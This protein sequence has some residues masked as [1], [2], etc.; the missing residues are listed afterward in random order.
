MSGRR[1]VAIG[2]GGA[3]VLLAALDAY[4]VTTILV[5]VVKDL[6][7]PVNRLERVTPVLTGFLLGYVAAM[8]LLGQLSDRFGRR[9]VLQAC[10]VFFAAGSV[11]TALAHDVPVLTGGRVVQGVAGGALLPVTM[12]LAGDL[13][14]ERQRPVVLGAVGAAQELGSVLGPLY[15]A[16]IAAALDWRAIFWI[17]LPLVAVAMA[18]VQ[19]AVPGGRPSGPRP[20]VDVVGG[21]LLA[22]GLGLLVAAVYNPE[23]QEAALPPWGLPALGAGAAVLAVFVLWEIRSRKRLLDLS[24]VRRGPLLATLG[25]SLLSGA[26]LMVT[27]VDVVLV[28][29]TVLHKDVTDGAL[30]LTRFLVALPVAAVA[31]GLVARRVGERW[32]MAVGMAVSAGGYL[33]IA[34]WPADLAGASYGPLPRMDVD[35]VVTG[36]GLGLV[37]APVSSAVL[38]FVPAARHGVA[39]AAVVVARMMGMLL[40]ISALTAWG[41]H[42]FHAL[43]AD[44]KPPLPFLMSKQEFAAQ[45]KIY[46][47]ALQ[48]ALRTEYREIFWI[49]AGMCLLGALLA[50]AAGTRRDAPPDAPA[51]GRIRAS[52]RHIGPETGDDSATGDVPINELGNILGK[53]G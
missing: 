37:I 50:L 35:L 3:V 6:G 42:R 34:G 23:P 39:S 9:P 30:L 21:L 45:M 25:V 10:L 5:P 27:L 19:V 41:F 48:D 29:Q 28:A 15:G 51:D 13:W 36:L 31:G 46:N 18:A 53:D 52:A 14:E 12:A 32:P 8:P 26:A 11:V 44:L 2:T 7:I 43:T 24:G 16:G 4:V 1:R 49:T 20:G 38:S 22:L 47:A 17:N 40:G 33:L